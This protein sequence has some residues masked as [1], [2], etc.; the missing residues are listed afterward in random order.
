MLCDDPKIKGKLFPIE[1]EAIKARNGYPDFVIDS[2]IHSSIDE[3]VESM[4]SELK[5]VTD[6]IGKYFFYVLADKACLTMD[7]VSIINKTVNESLNAHSIKSHYSFDLTD[8][9]SRILFFIWKK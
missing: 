2:G 1:Y 9:K 4:K 6:T 5:V 7:D 8:G 3:L